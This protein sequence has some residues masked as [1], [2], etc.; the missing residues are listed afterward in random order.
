[1][2]EKKKKKKKGKKRKKERERGRER[3]RNHLSI[4]RRWIMS[5]CNI[6]RTAAIS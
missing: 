5:S 3:E 6:F 4:I 1:V 2:K